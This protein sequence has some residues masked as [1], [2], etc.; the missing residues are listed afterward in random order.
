MIEKPIAD[1]KVGEGWIRLWLAFEALGAKEDKTREALEDL[2]NKLDSDDRV[3]V[4]KKDFT[5]PEFVENPHPIIKEGYSIT[6]ETE[7]I[8]RNLDNAVHVIME[9]GPSAVEILEPNKLNLGIGE[10]QGILNL[11][12]EMMHRFAAA[13]VGGIVIAGKKE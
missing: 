1:E 9:Y 11:I 13:G 6:C 2:I 3:K 12:S 4:Y 7:L 10:A 8:S 5:K